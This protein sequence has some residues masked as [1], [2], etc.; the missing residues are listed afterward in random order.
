MTDTTVGNRQHVADPVSRAQV[1]MLTNPEVNVSFSDTRNHSWTS[2]AGRAHIVHD[3]RKAEQLFSS[4][5]NASFPNGLETPGPT[6][7]KI[8]A[9]E[10]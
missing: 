9:V 1:A 3:R 2:I 5:L 8:E 6:L 10:L 7:I 4:T